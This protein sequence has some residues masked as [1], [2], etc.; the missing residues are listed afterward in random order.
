MTKIEE[1]NQ[2]PII[3]IQHLKSFINDN[4]LSSHE[5]ENLDNNSVFACG[6]NKT[7]ENLAV[8]LTTKNLL[9]NYIKQSNLGDLFIC[10]DGTYRLSNLDYPL[11]TLGTIDLNRKL[12]FQYSILNSSL[13]FVVSFAT[14]VTESNQTYSCLI[15]STLEAIK[16]LDLNVN[17]T[18]KYR[19]LI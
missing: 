11:L 18:P 2:Q 4:L 17:L 9:N 6:A 19:R 12:Q 13:I 16:V 15:E 3:S 14:T 1:E 10:A 7:D 8:V 5:I